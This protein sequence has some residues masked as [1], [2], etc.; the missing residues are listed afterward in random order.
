MEK[1]NEENKMNIDNDIETNKEIP[2]DEEKKINAG[3][4][5]NNIPNTSLADLNVSMLTNYSMN[6]KNSDK[7][8]KEDAV[9]IHPQKPNTDYLFNLEYFDEMYVNLLLDEKN[10]KFKINKNYM[11]E[12]QNSINVKMRGILVDWLIEIHS[13]FN[14]KRKTLF[15]TIYIIDL[16]LSYKAIEKNQFQLLGVAS[17]FIASKMN[18][19]YWPEIEKYV[20]ISDNAFTIQE[21]IKMELDIMK[22]IKF[23][24]LAPTAEEFFDIISKTYEFNSEQHFL[25]DYILDSSLIEY[26][27]LKFPPS[28]IGVSTAYVV[29]KFFKLKGYKDLYLSEFSMIE[30]EKKRKQTIKECAKNLCF[31][32]KGLSS[33]TLFKSTIEKYSLEEFGKVAELMG[34]K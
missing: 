8:L 25:G 10:S 9:I 4:S 28:I 16:Y 14:L 13:Q 7:S 31:L 21:L 2:M 18:E 24:I 11:K 23:D 20:G 6:S 17:L 19:I 30:T 1:G 34:S 5:Q 26:N 33:Q 27:L 3:K 32:I 12:C 15:Q 22:V 29:M